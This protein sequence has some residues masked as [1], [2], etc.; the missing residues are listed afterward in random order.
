MDDSGRWTEQHIKSVRSP[1][2]LVLKNLADVRK[3]IKKKSSRSL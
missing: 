3:L 1:E 2:T